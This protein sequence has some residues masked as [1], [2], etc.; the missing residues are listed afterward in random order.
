MEAFLRQS[1]AW[2]FVRS[3][4]NAKQ[5][6]LT[7]IAVA[8]ALSFLASDPEYR[9][10]FGQAPLDMLTFARTVHALFQQT[11]VLKDVIDGAITSVDDL[12]PFEK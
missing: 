11:D 7:E 3:I 2:E 1:E 9:H 6:L 4:S 8:R 5:R 12:N 10:T